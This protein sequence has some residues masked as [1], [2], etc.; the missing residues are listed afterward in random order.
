MTDEFVDLSFRI[1]NSKALWEVMRLLPSKGVTITG[2]SYGAFGDIAGTHQERELLQELSGITL[3]SG[4]LKT[5]KSREMILGYLKQ[6][7]EPMRPMA[8]ADGSGL[9]K[10]TIYNAI[11]RLKAE[12]LLKRHNGNRWG[13]TEK[14]RAG[15]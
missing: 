15:E 9:T 3:P 10:K 2:F 12:G 5:G 14:G 11:N 6:H 8:I 1:T 4:R 13:L 7:D